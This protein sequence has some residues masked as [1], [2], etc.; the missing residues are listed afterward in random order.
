MGDKKPVE[1]KGAE[2]SLPSS[3]TTEGQSDIEQLV[4]TLSQ[5]LKK[6]I[7]ASSENAEVKK[8]VRP[9]RVYSAGQSFKTWLSQFTQYAKL[10]QVKE[11]DR[12][13]YLLTLLDQPAFKAVELLKLPESLSYKDFTDRLIQRFDSGKTKED[14]KL[15]LRARRQKSGEDFEMFADS[16]VDLAENAYPEAEYAFK[17]ELA[18][19]QFIQGVIV[20]DDIREKLFVSQPTSIAEAVR[21]VRRLESARKAC[22]AQNPVEK[23]KT[24]NA[25]NTV[26]EDKVTTE[27]RELKGLVLEMNKRIKALEEKTE[28]KSTSPRRRDDVECYVCRNKGHFARECK[29]NKPSGNDSRGLSRPS[30]SP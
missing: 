20:S 12:R 2:G 15:Q 26:A 29:N 16:L 1:A 23:R 17:E 24:V 3:S 27:L 4:N 13:A 22:Q 5:V 9:P 19:D 21:L 18:R 6:S 25:V 10:V 7:V 8:N 11:S 30:Q 14:Y 28:V